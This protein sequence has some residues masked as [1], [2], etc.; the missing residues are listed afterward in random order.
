MAVKLPCGNRAC[1]LDRLPER[2]VVDG[3]RYWM[4]GYETGSIAPW[5]LA[6]TLFAKELGAT[7]G[8][9]ALSALTCWVRTCRTYSSEPRQ[10]FPFQCQRLCK[11]ECL[12]VS[13]IAALQHDD[14]PCAKFCLDRMVTADGVKDT[15]RSAHCLADSLHGLGQTLIP[16]PQT[17]VEDIATR[18]ARDHF[19]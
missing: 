12:A 3:Y 4:A 10:T 19:H 14:R 18:P 15:E 8:R 2:L 9:A 16:V 7:D 6:W 13:L 1:Y 11:D 5:E 17:I